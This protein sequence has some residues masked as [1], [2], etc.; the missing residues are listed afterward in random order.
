MV[1]EYS[2]ESFGEF[3]MHISIVFENFKYPHKMPDN[4]AF[5]AHCRVSVV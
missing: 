5:K 4:K 1:V 2:F 3:K